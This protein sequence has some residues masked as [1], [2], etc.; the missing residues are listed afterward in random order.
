V[1]GTDN[2]GI[3]P[4]WR[5][6]VFV[7]ASTIGVL[8]LRVMHSLVAVAVPIGARPVAFM[9]VLTGGLLI[10]HAWTFHLVEPRGWRCVGLGREALQPRLMALGALAGGAA[11]AIPAALLI[12][13]GW[14]QVTPTAEPLTPGAVAAPLALLV[15]AAMWEE[16][17]VRGYAFAVL[18]ERWGATGALAATSIAFGVLHVLNTGA[19]ARSVTVVTLAGIFLGLVLLR[20]GSLYAAWAAHL[21]WNL[22]L[23][24]VLHAAVSGLE[25][26]APGYRLTDAG[27]D[28]AT[29]GRWGPEGGLFAAAGLMVAAW[30]MTR[31]PTSRGEQ[32]HE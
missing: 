32:P 12:A 29:G 8:A 19:T 14:L 6:A 21:S 27:P 2:A 5:F 31:R 16:L 9:L 20:T 1:T 7:L 22:V 28:W 4:H 10:G 30:I 23:V 18:R 3:G 15:P 26:P 17:F 25:L 24:V 11:I 13:L